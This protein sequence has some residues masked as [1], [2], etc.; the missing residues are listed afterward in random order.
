MPAFGSSYEAINSNQHQHSKTK[1][2]I[3]VI[4]ESKQDRKHFQDYKSNAPEFFLDLG[5]FAI[6]QNHIQ[7]T[8]LYRAMK[9]KH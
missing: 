6:T 5:I 2:I 7:I 1:Y 4:I 9:R 8:T 3:I